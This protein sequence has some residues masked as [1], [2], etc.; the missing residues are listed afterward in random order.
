MV[1][2][3]DFSP[4][5]PI[6]KNAGKNSLKNG[7]CGIENGDSPSSNLPS[8]LGAKLA[9]TLAKSHYFGEHFCFP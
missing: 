1:G 8:P 9:K 7:V 6:G 3:R 2:G 4:Y 5:R